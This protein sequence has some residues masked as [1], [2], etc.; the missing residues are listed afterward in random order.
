MTTWAEAD[1]LRAE[2]L[3]K[4]PGSTGYQLCNH[5]EEYFPLYSYGTNG[6]RGG[7]MDDK[8]LHDRTCKKRVCADECYEVCD[9]YPP[10]CE[11]KFGH[12]GKH[13]AHGEQWILV[14]WDKK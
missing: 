3:K 5:C 13:K 4:Y 8:T 6:P 2:M 7:N 1:K 10:T 9:E 12:V 11:K 14:W